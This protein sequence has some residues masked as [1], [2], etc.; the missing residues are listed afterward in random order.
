M[1]FK[2]PRDKPK[3]TENPQGSS[4]DCRLRGQLQNV[5]RPEY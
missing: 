1:H 4:C 3:R 5:G 2:E